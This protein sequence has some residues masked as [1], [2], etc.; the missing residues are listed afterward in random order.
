MEQEARRAEEEE[1]E[2]MRTVEKEGTDE[3]E[4]ED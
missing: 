4:E 2:V 1:G 3:K